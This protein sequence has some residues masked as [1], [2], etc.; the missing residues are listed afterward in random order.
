M[1]LRTNRY[2]VLFP[3]SCVTITSGR[4]VGLSGVWIYRKEN[5]SS[6]LPHLG[7][8][9]QFLEMSSN[10]FKFLEIALN[11]FEFLKF[12]WISLNFLKFFL[13]SL[14]FFEFL[15]IPFNFC[16][17]FSISL[18]LNLT[19]DNLQKNAAR[20]I[21]SR[22]TTRQAESSELF[23]IFDYQGECFAP[24]SKFW[25]KITDSW[26]P[27]FP[28]AAGIAIVLLFQQS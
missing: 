8:S 25:P 24:L 21:P 1:S 2:N 16:K 6:G 18:N 15:S 14:N 9:F 3:T 19:L 27:L 17:F 20:R 11:F 4:F 5:V 22:W 23:G 26:W 10:F 28:W 13:I 12:L 7:I